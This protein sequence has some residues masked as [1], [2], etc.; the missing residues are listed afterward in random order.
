MNKNNLEEL[1]NYLEELEDIRSYI[2]KYHE[3][4]TAEKL[5][6]III[7]LLQKYPILDLLIIKYSTNS[8]WVKFDIEDELK[9]RVE[10]VIKSNN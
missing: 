7:N 2:F 4:D 9:R 6:Q 5:Q 3:G 8:I 10:D 1:S